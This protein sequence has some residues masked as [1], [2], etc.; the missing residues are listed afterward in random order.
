MKARTQLVSAQS[1]S[2]KLEQGYMLAMLEPRWQS[3]ATLVRIQTKS[4]W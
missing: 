3:C 1:W 2:L 4:K